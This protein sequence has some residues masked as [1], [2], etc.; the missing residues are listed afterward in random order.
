MDNNIE[1]WYSV[2]EIMEHLGVKYL[3]NLTFIVGT[4]NG[5]QIRYVGDHKTQ[6]AYLLEVKK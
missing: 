6:G 1:R 3:E 5:E 4:N 2:K